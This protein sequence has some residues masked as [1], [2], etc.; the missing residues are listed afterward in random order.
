MAPILTFTSE[1]IWQNMPKASKEAPIDSV[2]LLGWPK[3]DF[4]IDTQLDSI[5]ELIP[6]AAKAWKRC[7]PAAVLEAP[8]MPK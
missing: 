6:E 2:H 3:E 1:E 4:K 5:I 7:E 8:L